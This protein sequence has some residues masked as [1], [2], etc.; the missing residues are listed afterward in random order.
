MLRRIYSPINKWNTFGENS[1]I[2]YYTINITATTTTTIT[3]TTTT[4]INTTI[5]TTSS[6]FKPPYSIGI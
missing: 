6:S 5:T 2:R 1:I 3:T 4:T